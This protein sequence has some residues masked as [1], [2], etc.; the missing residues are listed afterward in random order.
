MFFRK[1]WPA[2]L[3]A[4]LILALCALPGSTIPHLK[5]LDWLRPDKIVH[6]I[7]FGVLSFLIIRGLLEQTSYPRLIPPAR[8]V[9]V[10]F[11]GIYGI[12]IELLQ[13][14]VF[15]SRTGEVYDAVA[16]FIGALIGLWFFNYWSRRRSAKAVS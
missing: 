9:A 13:E 8:K 3:W 12:V 1:T 10:V 11:S 7:L 16:D 2:L 5:F 6:F 14:Y 4:L 15:T